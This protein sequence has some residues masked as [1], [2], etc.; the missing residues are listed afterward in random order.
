M[1]H[2]VLGIPDPVALRTAEHLVAQGAGVCAIGGPEAR[3]LLP[4]GV[5]LLVGDSASIDFG[6]SG[7][8]YQGLVASVDEL[9]LADASPL[10]VADVERSRPVREAAEAAEFVRAGGAPRGVRFLSSLLVFGAAGGKVSEDDFEVGQRFRDGYEESLAVA[11]KI[12]RGLN[13]NC[14]LAIVRAAPLSGDEQTGEL[15]PGS[16]LAH[17][18]RIVQSGSVDSGYTFSDLPVYFETVERASQALI[19]VSPEQNMSVVHLVDQEPL[20]DRALIS[21]LARAAGKSVRERRS[22]WNRP[23][24]PGGRP[25][26]GW[27]LRFSR[28]RA[29][30]LLGDLLDREQS[31][32][33][34]GLFLSQEHK[35]AR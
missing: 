8:D 17:L 14:P 28:E 1:M 29:E 5:R 11:E 33:L 35:H 26:S 24:Y 2:L 10:P 30:R 15:Y 34:E 22:V 12:I 18:A 6:L 4:S 27:A 32:I 20:T 3:A 7:G 9:V 23:S 13:L 19:R 16:P 21:W 31:V 25:L